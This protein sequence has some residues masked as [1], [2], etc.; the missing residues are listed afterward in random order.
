MFKLR[1]PQARGLAVAAL[2]IGCAVSA[3]RYTEEPPGQII[4]TVAIIERVPNSLAAFPSLPDIRT[5]EERAD[6]SWHFD[7]E[8]M[9]P[10]LRDAAIRDVKRFTIRV[11]A[12]PFY[13]LLAAG[14]FLL[15]VLGGLR[16]SRW[17][18]TGP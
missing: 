3:W 15:L 7:I 14:L 16:I 4:R 9:R 10:Y 13:G 2:I 8:E 12:V 5:E 17:I 1:T 11:M 6:K 18:Q